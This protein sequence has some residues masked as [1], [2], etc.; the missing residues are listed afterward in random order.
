MKDEFI[1]KVEVDC[2]LCIKIFEVNVIVIMGENEVKIVIVNFEVLCCE[3]EVELF[4]KVILVE[5]VQQV[6]VFEEVYVV[7]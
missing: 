5:K 6:K 7:E 1:G 3:W 2:D 4:C